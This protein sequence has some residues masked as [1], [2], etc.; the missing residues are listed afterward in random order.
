MLALGLLA[1]L[2]MGLS[3]VQ[4]SD[5]AIKMATSEQMVSS[6]THSCGQCGDQP[7]G[8]KTM[9][10]EANCVAPAA[11]MLPQ[12]LAVTFDHAADYP[13]WRSAGLSGLTVSPDPSPPKFIDLA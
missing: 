5:M 8:V 2:G 4:A 6:G 12:S 3:A 7:G 1:A 11:A 10:C 13:S 9:A